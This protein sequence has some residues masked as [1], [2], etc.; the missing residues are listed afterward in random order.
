MDKELIRKILK[1]ELFTKYQIDESFDKPFSSFKKRTDFNYIVNEDGV[2][3]EFI[4]INKYNTHEL[5]NDIID[6]SKVDIYYELIWRWGENMDKKLKTVENWVKMTTTSF[7]IIDDFIRTMKPLVIKFSE[8]SRGNYKIYSH[9][10]FINR[11]S[12]L[13]DDHFHVD[14]SNKV[15]NK[16]VVIYLIN[17]EVSLVMKDPINKRAE[18]CTNMEESRQYWLYPRKRDQKGIIRNDTIKEQRKR[19]LYKLKYLF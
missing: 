14:V 5:P 12:V 7:K 4:F 11:L 10:E 16:N 6:N 3:G 15:K 19:I 18:N 9:S 17:K 2:I 13:F 1:E 8:Q